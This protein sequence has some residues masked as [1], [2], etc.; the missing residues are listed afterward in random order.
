MQADTDKRV[1]A[2]VKGIERYIFQYERGDELAVYRTLGRFAGDAQLSFSWW[3][4]AVLS[5]RIRA[6][7]KGGKH[8]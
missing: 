4:A 3:D 7:E 5:Q 2:F 6:R 8:A 1:V